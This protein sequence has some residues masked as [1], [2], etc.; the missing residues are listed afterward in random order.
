MRHG[1]NEPRLALGRKNYL[2]VHDSDSGA[3]IAGH[4]SLVAMCEARVINPFEYVTRRPRARAGPPE[5][6]D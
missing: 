1:Q 2:F 6:R 3:S 4:Y 5:Q